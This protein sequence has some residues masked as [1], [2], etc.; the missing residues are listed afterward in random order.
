MSAQNER[1]G[2]WAAGTPS[3]EAP[4]QQRN[5]TRY[6]GGQEVPATF[7]DYL[8]RVNPRHL[9]LVGGDLLTQREA[10]A[11]AVFP[12]VDRRRRKSVFIADFSGTTTSQL[13]QDGKNGHSGVYEWEVSSNH[14]DLM[15]KLTPKQLRELI[16]PTIEIA[17]KKVG[18]VD[19][20]NI[21]S[22]IINVL[23][24]ENGGKLPSISQINQALNRLQE[25]EHTLGRELGNKV[26]EAFYNDDID[27]PLLKSLGNYY[28]LLE[29][30][31]RGVGLSRHTG[32][33]GIKIVNCS[34][35]E[36]GDSKERE[37]TRQ[38]ML[39]QLLLGVVANVPAWR[40]SPINGRDWSVPDTL[41]IAGADKVDLSVL[42]R[43]RKHCEDYDI[44]TVFSYDKIDPKQQNFIGA[45]GTVGVMGM[46]SGNEAKLVSE[47]LGEVKVNKLNV[48]ESF[49]EVTADSR[50]DE[51]RVRRDSHGTVAGSRAEGQVG[52]TAL[53]IS[54]DRNRNISID[55]AAK[56]EARL[57]ER[58]NSQRIFLVTRGNGAAYGPLAFTYD[59]VEEAKTEAVAPAV[60]RN[61]ATIRSTGP[62]H[63]GPVYDQSRGQLRPALNK[64][65]PEVIPG[66]T[67]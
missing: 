37:E 48:S 6:E 16:T 32:A 47:L 56:L 34:L 22:K 36:R 39:T 51:A 62:G 60:D 1:G 26:D 57:I 10:I 40:Q 63:F 46:G 59:Q 52:T 9:D 42:E 2:Q 20:Q 5:L 44:R 31:D 25:R 4:R 15:D 8:S 19:I 66:T 43:V 65:R 12:D 55:T 3:T 28:T 24:T 53:S 29:D 49:H 35:N 58:L 45:A 23:A 14:T 50:A 13:V 30:E 7:Y 21:L 33:R 11:A 54:H 18:D 17:G 64:L 38:R 67:G 41:V 61:E 27:K